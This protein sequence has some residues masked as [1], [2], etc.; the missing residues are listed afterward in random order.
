MRMQVFGGA[1]W[2]DVV[3]DVGHGPC[4]VLGLWRDQHRHAAFCIL[5][6]GPLDVLAQCVG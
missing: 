1:M 6:H 4:H 3:D 2:F 5:Q